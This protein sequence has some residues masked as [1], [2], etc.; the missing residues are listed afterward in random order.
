MQGITLQQGKFTSDGTAKDLNIRSDVDWM[1]V[2]NYTQA[3]TQATPGVGVQYY[4]QRGMATDTGIEYVKAD[5]ADTLTMV[6][7]SS[8]GFSLLDTTSQTPGAEVTG[9]TITKAAPPVC[10]ATSHGYITGDIVRIYS[11]DEM[12]QMNG[13]EFS[14]TRTGANTFTLTNMD[15]NTSNFTQSA[16]FKARRITNNPI[17]YPRNRVITDISV[18]SSAIVTMAVT[19]G[20][21]AGQKVRL[22]V[23]SAF[24]MVEMDGLQ[25]TVTAIGAADANGYTNTITLDIDSAAFTAF[26][27]P[28]ASAAPLSFAQV[29]PI[30]EAA[31]GTYANNLDDATDNQAIIGMRLEA[32]TNSPAGA[33][34]DVIYWV[35][36]KSLVVDN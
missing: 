34:S 4:W 14:V 17:F 7:L 13:L 24:G 36:G 22:A 16:A 5:G 1:T 33:T 10:T 19:H 18:A 32:G 20:L 9:T 2:Y 31:T 6:T 21:T 28:A 29:I 3:A 30:G 12:D 11:S 8:G 26:A 27:W 25:A 15:T 23:P 35:A